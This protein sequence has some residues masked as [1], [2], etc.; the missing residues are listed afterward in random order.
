MAV[1]IKNFRFHNQ[2]S[3]SVGCSEVLRASLNREEAR[4]AQKKGGFEVLLSE[5]NFAFFASSR[6]I[7]PLVCTNNPQQGG[8]LA[9]RY[10]SSRHENG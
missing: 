5:E 10:R 4:Y 6:L 8:H 9:I 7:L 2:Q 1:E 3:L